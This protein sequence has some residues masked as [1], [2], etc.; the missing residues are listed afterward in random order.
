M[1]SVIREQ[2]RLLRQAVAATTKRMSS[3]GVTIIPAGTARW[4][5]RNFLT[6]P[7]GQVA[8]VVDHDDTAPQS[9]PRRSAGSPRR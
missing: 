8:P 3:F 9:A 1:P 2:P 4:T 5:T 7:P 6:V